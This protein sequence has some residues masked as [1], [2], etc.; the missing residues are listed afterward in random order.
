MAGISCPFTVAASGFGDGLSFEEKD[1]FG[2]GFGVLHFLDGDLLH[3]FSELAKI[4][5]L[6]F[7]MLYHILADSGKLSGSGAVQ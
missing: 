3:L 6:Q 1:P 2:Q 7:I 5:I 4:F